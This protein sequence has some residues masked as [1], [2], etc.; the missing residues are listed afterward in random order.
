LLK[1]QPPSLSQGETAIHQFGSSNSY[2]PAAKHATNAFAE[3]T[4]SPAFRD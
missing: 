2:E 3:I 1:R 4:H